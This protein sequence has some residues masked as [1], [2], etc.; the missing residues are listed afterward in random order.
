MTSRQNQ[1]RNSWPAKLRTRTLALIAQES[2]SATKKRALLLP[3]CA[4]DIWILIGALD[5]DTRGC[6]LCNIDFPQRA[7]FSVLR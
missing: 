7:N 1:S 4:L 3:L 5:R 6:K 2:Y